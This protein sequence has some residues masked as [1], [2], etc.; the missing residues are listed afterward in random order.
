LWARGALADKVATSFTSA[1]TGHGGLEATILAINTTFY[2][3]GS[4]VLPL[5]YTDGSVDATGNPYGSS[6]VGRQG[7]PPDEATLAA[8][9]HQGVRLARFA[10]ALRAIR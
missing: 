5:G 6:W 1:S 2:H 8:A 4:L 9:R 7:E 10:D 3:W